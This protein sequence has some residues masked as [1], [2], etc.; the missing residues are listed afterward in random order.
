MKAKLWNIATYLLCLAFPIILGAAAL[1]GYTGCAHVAA[2]AQ[3]CK[4]TPGDVDV[5]LSSLQSDGWQAAL[6]QLVVA[7]GLCVARAAVQQVI[8]AL[9]GQHA[10][11]LAGTPSSDEVVSRGR[12][13]LAANPQ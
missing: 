9:S 3:V 13:W 8:D 12:A 6:E 10:L 4:P 7:K 1:Y 11:E 5:A 2:V